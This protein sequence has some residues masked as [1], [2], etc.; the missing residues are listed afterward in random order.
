MSIDERFIKALH[1]ETVRK[2]DLGPEDQPHV[3][4]QTSTIDALL[5]GA[6]DGDVS[7]RELREHGA[8]GLGTLD[9]L[10]GEMIA[11]D[12]RFYRPP[13]T[14]RS[15]RLRTPLGPRSR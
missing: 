11:L 3:I 2:R 13:P 15:R 4:F 10:D 5:D 6:Y 14:A 8:F 1:L 7:F 9:A 12:G